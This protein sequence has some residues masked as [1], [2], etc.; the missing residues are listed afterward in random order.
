MDTVRL[1]LHL[2]K[3][4]EGLLGSEEVNNFRVQGTNPTKY[5]KFKDK[6]CG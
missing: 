1:F 2:I 5:R 6:R 3:L 4:A